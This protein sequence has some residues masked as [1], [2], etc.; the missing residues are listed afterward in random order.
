M[1]AGSDPL[2]WRI[3]GYY[4]AYFAALGIFL[5]FW[6]LYLKEEGFSPAAIG[7]LMGLFGLTKL[8][9][10][11]IVGWLSDHLGQPMRWVRVASLLTLILFSTVFAGHGLWG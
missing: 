11:L 1:P 10:P 3:P 2:L 4:F 8:A 6:P 7:L 5:P 9:G